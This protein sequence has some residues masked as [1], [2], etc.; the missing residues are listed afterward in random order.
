M[1]KSSVHIKD[2]IN[3]KQNKLPFGNVTRTIVFSI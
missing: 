1:I 2:R 3:K